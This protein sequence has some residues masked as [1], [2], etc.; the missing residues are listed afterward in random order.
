MGHGRPKT[1]L[2]ASESHV[3]LIHMKGLRT[4]QASGRGGCSPARAPHRP[5]PRV[6]NGDVRISESK[7]RRAAGRA[8]SRCPLWIQD[9]APGVL[10]P[11]SRW[12]QRPR[13]LRAAAFICL[14]SSARNTVAWKKGRPRIAAR[15]AVSAEQG[16]RDVLRVRDARRAATAQRVTSRS[17][18]HRGGAAAPR[19]GAREGAGQGAEVSRPR[20]RLRSAPGVPAPPLG[21]TVLLVGLIPVPVAGHLPAGPA[22]NQSADLLLPTLARAGFSDRLP[23]D[24]GFS[25]LATHWSPF[26]RF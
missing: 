17:S 3:V 14:G 21:P 24:K 10:R 18:L 4:R 26:G 5:R 19:A 2:A 1:A 20:A 25:A 9:A 12:P 6:K 13:N 16:K 23:P 22:P 8:S 11:A 15:W 7:A